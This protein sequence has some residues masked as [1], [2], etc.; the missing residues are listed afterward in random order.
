MPGGVPGGAD[1]TGAR[2]GRAD[3]TDAHQGGAD[4]HQGGADAHQ[5]GADAHQGGADAHQ[6]GAD[7][8]GRDWDLEETETQEAERAHLVSGTE[9]GSLSGH[10]RSGASGSHDGSGDL[11]GHGGSGVSNGEELPP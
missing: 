8:P 1:M 6:G 5:G 7:I 9:A 3:E 11:M 10:G 4:A 2:Q